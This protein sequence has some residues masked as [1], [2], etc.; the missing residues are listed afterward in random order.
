MRPSNGLWHPAPALVQRLANKYLNSNSWRIYEKEWKVSHLCVFRF[1]QNA[2]ELSRATIFRLI[3]CWEIFSIHATLLPNAAKRC[4]MNVEVKSCHKLKW[5]N[6][7][8]CKTICATIITMTRI[9][10]IVEGEQIAMRCLCIYPDLFWLFRW[11][12]KAFGK[13]GAERHANAFAS[14]ILKY[15]F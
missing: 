9:S 2:L 4:Q 13:C 10:R 11:K 3:I 7:S 6:Y 14:I 8:R 1:P 12:W 5:R 15:L